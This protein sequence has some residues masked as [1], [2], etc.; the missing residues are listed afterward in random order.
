MA[1]WQDLENE[2]DHW[3]QAGKTATLWWRDDDACALTP[4]LEKLIEIADIANIP[5]HLAVIPARLEDDA[6]KFLL[7]SENTRILQHGFAHIDHAPKGEGSWELGDHRPLEIVVGEL[8][9][10]FDILHVAF[11]EKF[12]PVLVPPWTRFSDQL[13]PFLPDVGL[14]AYSAEGERERHDGVSR[15]KTIHAHCDPIRWKHNARFKGA[16]RVLDDFVAHL[17]KRRLNQCD[18][19]EPSGL[20]THHMDHSLELWQFLPT[21]FERTKSHPAVDWI[22]IEAELL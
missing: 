2:L 6:T 11:G 5:V 10:G 7:A 18:A 9:Q 16:E 15:L 17:G 21:F 4:Q 8:K 13:R 22:S 3:H 1:T 12:L 14:K 19:T 20:C